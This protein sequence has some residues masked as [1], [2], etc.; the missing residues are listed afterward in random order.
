MFLS[1]QRRIAYH[2]SVTGAYKRAKRAFSPRRE[3]DSWKINYWESMASHGGSQ[4]ILKKPPRH[5]TASPLYFAARRLLTPAHNLFGIP[6]ICTGS[7]Q[8]YA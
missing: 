6:L 5:K 4:G 3:E 7:K 1:Y 2:W 8:I